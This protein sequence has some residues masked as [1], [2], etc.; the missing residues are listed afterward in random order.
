[1]PS[2]DSGF[3][4]AFELEPDGLRDAILRPPYACL[5]VLLLCRQLRPTSVTAGGCRSL[6]PRGPLLWPPSPPVSPGLS[7][8]RDGTRCIKASSRPVSCIGDDPPPPSQI[9]TQWPPSQ[10]G[11]PFHPLPLSPPSARTRPPRTHSLL[12]FVP[13]SRAA[14][15]RC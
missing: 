10:G 8:R 2:G 5:L 6:R 13:F 1:M 14:R 15:T 11:L 9:L 4:C 3:L 7:L 12:V